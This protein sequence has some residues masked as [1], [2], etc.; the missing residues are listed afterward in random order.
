MTDEYRK[1]LLRWG[2]DEIVKQKTRELCYAL[3]DTEDMTVV[4]VY[5]PGTFWNKALEG[6]RHLEC[7]YGVIVCDVSYEIL[8]L[9]KVYRPFNE[10]ST[11][12]PPSQMTEPKTQN[13]SGF[14]DMTV[15]KIASRKF[16]SYN[17]TNFIGILADGEIKQVF[18]RG[19]P[20]ENI[21]AI[22]LIFSGDIVMVK[23]KATYEITGLA[24][25]EKTYDQLKQ[26]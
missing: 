25:I 19:T 2:A 3:I 10:L 22:A 7:G 20:L 26:G 6:A 11:S 13:F 23:A 16:V 17:T 14:K 18:P 5:S 21:S 4:N 24:K 15:A 1:C 12:T 9:V 8:P